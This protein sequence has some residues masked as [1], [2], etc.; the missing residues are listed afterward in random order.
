[1]THLGIELDPSSVE[2]PNV[3]FPVTG[4]TRLDQDE[5]W[6]L[7]AVDDGDWRK[8]RFHDYDEVFSVPGL[9]E[10]LFYDKLKCDSPRTVVSLLCKELSKAG[11]GPPDLTVLDVGAGNGMVGKEL[12]NRGANTL[13][14]LDII[15]EAKLAVE[16]DRPEV[17][18][19][20]YVA[21]LTDLPDRTRRLLDM[22]EFN[23][24]T[25]VAALGFGDIPPLA[26]AQA[27]NLISAPGW[28][29]FNIQER[30]ID[31]NEDSSGFSRLI[32]EMFQRDIMGLCAARRYRHRLSLSGE[33]LYYVA[34]VARKKEDIP[35]ELLA[36]ED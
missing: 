5:E 10:Y 34:V 15:E 14:G 28:V 7:V 6:C 26:F 24:L 3:R 16:R 29:A 31:D 8:I 35:D 12:Q 27:Y 17:Y 1:M 18:D 9:Y 22:K 2:V 23:C 11:V 13:V 33:G 4:E 32:T 36:E 19:E 20:Y 30:F 25:T 21:D